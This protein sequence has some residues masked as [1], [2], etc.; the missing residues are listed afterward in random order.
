MNGRAQVEF[1]TVFNMVMAVYYEHHRAHIIGLER[2]FEAHD[3]NKDGYVVGRCGANVP[4]MSCGVAKNECRHTPKNEC[5]TSLS[6]ISHV[7]LT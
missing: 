5:A 6:G 4:F 7:A 1:D 3:K 2:L